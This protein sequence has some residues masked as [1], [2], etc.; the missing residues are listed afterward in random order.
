[1]R[2]HSLD[3]FVDRLLLEQKR[4]LQEK[5]IMYNNGARYGQV[6]W[7]AG[8]AGSGKGF[9][10]NNFMQGEL[11]KV[12]NPDSFKEF[13]LE[14]ARETDRYPELAG[15]D[16]RN[17]ED[18]QDLHFFVKRRGIK[19]RF[20]HNL[21]SGSVAGR[22]PNILFDTTLD[23]LDNVYD[24]LPQLRGLGYRPSGMH[25]TWVLSDYSVAVERNQKR[26]RVVPADIVLKTHDGA[27]RTMFDIIRGRMPRGVD[28]SVRIIL[29][30]TEHTV[31]HDRNT[32]SR[33]MGD[34]PFLTGGGEPTS[35][36]KGFKYITLKEAG[37]PFKSNP[38]LQNEV[39]RWMRNNIPKTTD[40][41]RSMGDL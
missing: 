27:A 23:D 1:M 13:Y 24:V 19:G 25:I 29:N 7:L 3:L 41:W 31:Y 35:V 12:M 21:L 16:L 20:L 33:E 40:L 26:D 5:L 38:E 2:N 34:Q 8:G 39:F 6:V 18:V 9:A 28:G 30:N 10:L 32:V 11:F 14:L 37:K 22:L 17:P 15:L 36:V 4:L